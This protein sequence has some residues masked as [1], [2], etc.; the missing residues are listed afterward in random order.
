MR[1]I[2]F[3]ILFAASVYNA[4]AARNRNG[5]FNNTQIFAVAIFGNCALVCIAFGW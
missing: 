5:E 3:S 1:A 4:H 2:A